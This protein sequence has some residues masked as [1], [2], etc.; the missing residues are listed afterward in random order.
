MNKISPDL[1][2]DFIVS[3]KQLSG[4]LNWTTEFIIGL[5]S[6]IILIIAVSIVIYNFFKVKHRYAFYLMLLFLSK[7]LWVS[8]NILAALFLSKLLGPMVTYSIVVLTFFTMLCVDAV[9]RESVDQVK[10]SIF[11]VLSAVVV[12]TSLDP[13][14]V[15]I[16]TSPYGELS[17]WASG[18]FLIASFLLLLFINVMWIYY[19][20]RIHW[21]TPKNLK[22]YSSLIFFGALVL[23]SDLF[24]LIIGLNQIILG[25]HMLIFAVGELL[26]AIGFTSQP[27]LAYILPF[28]VLRLT[29]IEQNSGLSLFNHTWS[30]MDDLLDEQ[31]FSGMLQGISGILQESLKRGNVREINLD[32]AVLILK[33]SE[34]FPVACV[35]VTT[36]SSRSLRDALN[37]FA[38]KFFTEFSQFFSEPHKLDNFSPASDLVSDCFSFIPEYD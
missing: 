23:A 34:Q 20:A 3:L 15:E 19:M 10:M 8:F 1:I 24:I 37:S 5:P 14:S 22:F 35:L 36:K 30:K 16:I 7:P 21:N 4:S 32:Q 31:L 12:F 17:L 18:Y 28:K 26:I 27:K 29:V 25:L 38:E 2:M 6:L 13:N 11:L 33:R 9:S